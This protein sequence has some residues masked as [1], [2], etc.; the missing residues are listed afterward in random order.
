GVPVL[1]ADAR[2]DAW[3][4]P[5]VYT[6]RPPI[7]LS[8]AGKE[9]A[10][11]ASGPLAVPAGSTVIV[12]SSGGALD[13]EWMQIIADVTGIEFEV[14]ENPRNAGAL[15]SAIVALIGLKELSGFEA[16]RDFVK[17]AAVYR[18]NHKNAFVYNELFSIYKRLYDDLKKS[19]KIANSRR[20]EGEILG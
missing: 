9:S 2:L 5:P 8:S 12:R 1:S 3:V 15:G 17:V 11:P 7:I 6:G 18:P 13:V 10:L 4:T 16:A 20:F 19:Y 14:V